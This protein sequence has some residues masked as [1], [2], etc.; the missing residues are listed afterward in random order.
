MKETQNFK[1]ALSVT[2]NDN[3]KAII[4]IKQPKEKEKVHDHDTLC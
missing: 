1:G 3:D 4:P 2:R